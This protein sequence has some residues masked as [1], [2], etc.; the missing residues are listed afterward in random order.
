[1]YCINVEISWL[2]AEAA[3]TNSTSQRQIPPS[4][5]QNMEEL[6]L[7]VGTQN[8]QCNFKQLI[9]RYYYVQKQWEE[10]F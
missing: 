6:I 3:H 8:V 5:D 2:T 9:K 4:T 7:N 1:M 10:R